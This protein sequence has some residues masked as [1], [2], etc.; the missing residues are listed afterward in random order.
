MT[1]PNPDIDP[2]TRRRAAASPK[3][4]LEQLRSILARSMSAMRTKRTLKMRILVAASNPLCSAF[5][6]G[7][8]SNAECATRARKS[9]KARRQVSSDCGVSR[10]FQRF[11]S[12]SA[13]ICSYIFANSGSA[14]NS[15]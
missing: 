8:V 2:T 13:E 14:S 12:N 4:S 3:R 15:S 7:D 5:L 6:G 9:T 1:R 11:S 10:V